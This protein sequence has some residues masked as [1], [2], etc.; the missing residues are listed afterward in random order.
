M[1]IELQKITI[2]E[3]VEGYVDDPE[4]GVSG[5]GGRYRHFVIPTSKTA[6]KIANNSE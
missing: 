2:R 6:A 5:Y 1:K 3:L 4:G